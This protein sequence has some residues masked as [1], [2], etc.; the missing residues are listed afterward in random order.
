MFE[1]QTARLRLRAWRD[2]DIDPFAAM[3]ADPRVMEHFPSVLSRQE[4]ADRLEKIRAK[5]AERGYGLWPV[6]RLDGGAFVGVVGLAV[7]EFQAHFTPCVEIGWR[8]V[9][10]H[11]GRGYATEAARAV[12]ALGFRRYGLTEIVS[13]TTTAN[14]RSW[15]VMEKLGM[16]RDPGDDFQ[17]PTLPPDHPL[18]PHVLYRI[19]R[20]A[21][22]SGAP[23]GAG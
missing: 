11:W 5:I 22:E 14:T 13:M 15:R 21:F 18:A 7:P 9:A 20:S 1:L 17:H 6:E 23:G 10:S 16:R 8:L 2:S 3:N 19:S 12:L 4:S